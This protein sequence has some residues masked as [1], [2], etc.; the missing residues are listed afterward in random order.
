MRTHGTRSC[1]VMGCRCGACMEA[2][3]D[4]SRTYYRA[5]RAP[6][7]H[8]P[9]IDKTRAAR[10]V[11]RLREAGMGVREIATAAGVTRQTIARIHDR[12]RG[13]RPETAQRILAVQYDPFR[14]DAT[15]SRRRVQALAALGWTR[16][17]IATAGGL[18]EHGIG[19][20]MSGK[21]TVVYRT[22]ARGIRQAYDALSMRRGPSVRARNRAAAAGWPPPLAW[23]DESID[24]PT[25]RPDG[26]GYQPAPLIESIRELIAHGLDREA[27][28]R[29]LGVTRDTVDQAITRA[30]KAAA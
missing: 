10:H 17:H 29:R 25:A 22:T 7:E 30:R 9:H 6:I 3:R 23:D 24:D 21:V 12:T 14:V 13:I 1:Y 2:Q 27:I 16:D 11:A 5:Y 28:A 4:Y 19:D 26:A 20:V 18:N 15:G 8:V